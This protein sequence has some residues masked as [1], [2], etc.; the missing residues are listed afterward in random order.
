MGDKIGFGYLKKL[1]GNTVTVFKGGPHSDTGEL[2]A[3]KKDYLVLKKDED[4]YVYF[5]VHHLKRVIDNTKKQ[6]KTSTDAALDET[7]S[8][9]FPKTFLELL[10]SLRMKPV[11]INGGKHP[12]NQGYLLDANEEFVVISSKEGLVFY[13]VDHI[14]N[15]T[16]AEVHEG[17]ELRPVDFAGGHLFTDVLREYLHKWTTIN[18]G[19]DKVEGV[20]VEVNESFTILVK[21]DEVI[22][23]TNESIKLIK[24]KVNEEKKQENNDNSNESKDKDDY[25]QS[26][27]KN[28]GATIKRMIVEN[29]VKNNMVQKDN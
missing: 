12:A 20:L 15:V 3:V 10:Q 25:N 8:P 19:P 14:K 21:N 4:G 29:L 23:V 1:V 18:E 2:V 9:D 17:E 22:Y 28:R 27:G 16:A 5:P 26:R 13:R 24:Q 7:T 11:G 6:A